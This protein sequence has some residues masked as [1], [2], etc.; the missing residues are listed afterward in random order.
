[1]SASGP[2]RVRGHLPGRPAFF[3]CPHFRPPPPFFSFAGELTPPPFFHV[4]R[5]DSVFPQPNLFL[6]AQRWNRGRECSMNSSF[7]PL[8]PSCDFNRIT[9]GVGGRRFRV[10]WPSLGKSRSPRRW[11]HSSGGFLPPPPAHVMPKASVGPGGRRRASGYTKL[12]GDLAG[13][14]PCIHA[15][16]AGIGC[17]VQLRGCLTP[18]R[19]LNES[20]SRVATHPSPLMQEAFSKGDFNLISFKERSRAV[21]PV[22]NCMWT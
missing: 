2:W 6:L 13:L 20:C 14:V 9:L 12:L 7:S 19:L 16:L 4:I 1:M 15:A 10:P 3:S 21:F 8:S 22:M 18:S 5:P 17:S 11:W